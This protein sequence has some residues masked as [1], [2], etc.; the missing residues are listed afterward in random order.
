MHDNRPDPDILLARVREEEAQQA[1]GKLKIF[2]GATAGVGKTYAMLE[3]AHARCKEGVDVVVG[4]VDTH[5]RAETEALLAELEVLPRRSVAYRGTTL[6]AFDLDAALARRPALLLVDELAHT[7]APGSRHAKRW[8]DVEELLD[9]GI[10]VY[11]TV[12]VQHLESLNDVVAQ[13]TGVLVRETVPDS[14]LDQA[15]ELELIDLPPDELLQRLREG[16]VYVPEQAGRALDHFFS[17]GNLIALRELALRRTADRVDAQM[18]VYRATHAI[19]ETWPTTERI[20]VCVSPSPLSA[21]LVRATRRMAARLRAEWLAVSV[22]TPA[23]LRLPEADRDRVV[24]TL[25]LAEQL[26]A[27]SVTLSGENV[28]EELLNYARTRNVSKIVVGKPRRPR[29]KE[30]VFGSVVD[31]LARN[32]DDI[33]V[34]VISGEHDDSRP[35]S[36]RLPAR[37]SSGSAYGWALAVVMGCTTLDWLLFPAFEKANLVM[38]YLL[39]VTVFL[40]KK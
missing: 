14:I 17:K 23:S 32:T 4:W 25:R 34:Y 37:T 28:S 40:R 21:R 7:N 6:E 35:P 18:Q 1:R 19:T 36:L 15:D 27:E 8:Q 3:A 39:G 29:W 30:I 26:G 11:T 16:K 5:G 12:N 9:A 24:H 22:E 10:D 33:D 38:V 31:E 2:F 20:L 13:I